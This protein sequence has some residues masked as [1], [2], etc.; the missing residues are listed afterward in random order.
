MLWLR[1]VPRSRY[2]AP[3][4]TVARPRSP[5]FLT[6]DPE[7]LLAQ[8]EERLS[9]PVSFDKPLPTKTVPVSV[10]ACVPSRPARTC[11]C[12]TIAAAPV[13][14]PRPCSRMHSSDKP[15]SG[16]LAH[17]ALRQPLLPCPSSGSTPTPPR[18]SGPGWPTSCCRQR[19]VD[20]VMRGENE[21][22]LSDCHVSVGVPCTCPCRNASY[23]SLSECHDSIWSAV[24]RSECTSLSECRHR[25]T[26]YSKRTQGAQ[27]IFQPSHG[28][29]GCHFAGSQNRRCW[30]TSLCPQRQ[31]TSLDLSRSSSWFNS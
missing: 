13:L 2:G 16:P 31:G 21:V 15:R 9:T 3:T 22:T 19:V 10:P 23:L 7:E 27:P 29:L 25:A 14:P 6:S 1:V 26:N 4:L 24:S 20:G 28:L 17:V 18:N 5:S 8:L 11:L 30:Q 12:G